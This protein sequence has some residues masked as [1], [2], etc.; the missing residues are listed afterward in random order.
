MKKAI[1]TLFFSLSFLYSNSCSCFG[2]FKGY[3][4]YPMTLGLAAKVFNNLT[5]IEIQHVDSTGARALI[6]YDYCNSY[7]SD[8]IFIENMDPGWQCGYSTDEFK[9][10]DKLLTVLALPDY[11]NHLSICYE[12]YINVTN[13][14]TSG[15]ISATKTVKAKTWKISEIESQLGITIKN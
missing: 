1:L 9:T 2:G 14:E 5:F 15:L 12:S 4:G 6:I 11:K 10:G 3:K 7:D 8:T 13:E